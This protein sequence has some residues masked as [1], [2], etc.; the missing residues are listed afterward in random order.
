[1]FRTKTR[2]I[3]IDG[4]RGYKQPLDAVVGWNC[5]GMSSDSPCPTDVGL[6]ESQLAKT[7]LKKNK[8]PFRR[9]VCNTSNV[10]CIHIYLIVP[11]EMVEKA[12][13]LLKDWY[14]N[15][16]KEETRLLYL[17]EA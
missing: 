14:N 13:A 5:T 10:F 1:M 9:V 8:I 2:Y 7:F 4:W 3:R 11:T 16:I 12:R 6:K 17:V 15:G